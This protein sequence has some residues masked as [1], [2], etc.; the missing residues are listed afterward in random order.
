[1]T[2]REQAYGVIARFS[3]WFN[4]ITGGPEGWSFSARAYLDWLESEGLAKGF[5]WV[6]S[7]T[8]DVVF[9]PLDGRDHTKRA[10]RSHFRTA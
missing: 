4:M 3:R 2:P 5:W 8:I 10:F 6:I 7:M 1:M 9:L